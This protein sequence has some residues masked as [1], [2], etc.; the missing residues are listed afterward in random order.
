MGGKVLV[1]GAAGFIGMHVAKALAMRGDEVCALD[2]F[3]AYYDVSL[4]HARAA[5]LKRIRGI[6]VSALDI[7]DKAALDAFFAR[8]KPDRV[9]HL[10]AQP[11][12][13]HGLKH[14]EDY[15]ASNLVGFGN[16]LEA[17]RHG[18]VKHLT[19]ASSSS[20]YGQNGKM[21]FSE[22]DAVDHP[23]SLYAATKKS[24]ELMA[25]SYAHLFGLPCTGLRFFTVYG[26]WG[27]PDMAVY[28]FTRAILEGRPIQLFNHGRMRRDFTYID[29][30]VAGVI[31]ALD[32]PAAAD[33]AWTA[34]A[35]SP[36][37]SHAPWRVFNIGNNRAE[38]LSRFVAVLE[39]AC[40]REAIKEYLPMQ[41]GDVP[42]TYADVSALGALTGYAPTTP[43]DVGLPRFVEWFRA[44]H[45]V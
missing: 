34:E 38:E 42:A 43:I 40:A 45:R 16:M 21:P 25:H 12:V 36:A 9:V 30:I 27:R 26:P 2:S 13:R 15:I 32:H 14:P 4:K 1:T 11:G 39:A 28:L 22:E 18:G 8:E 24:N 6:E 19:Y 37:T 44:Y 23:L 7:A 20:V 10:A 35:P 41:P 17:C 3:N 5:E 29:D 33:P 31:G